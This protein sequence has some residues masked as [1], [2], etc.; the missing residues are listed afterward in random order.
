MR[1][2]SADCCLLSVVCYVVC[3]GQLSRHEL[4][5]SA[6][7]LQS[8][9]HSTPHHTTPHPPHNAPTYFN[10]TPHHT[11]QSTTLHIIP[12]CTSYHTAHHTINHTTPHHTINHTAYHT[13]HSP[14]SVPKAKATQRT[15][16]AAQKTTLNLVPIEDTGLMHMKLRYFRWRDQTTKTLEEVRNGNT[17]TTRAH[18]LPGPPHPLR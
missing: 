15:V 5:L 14:L 1:T 3:E 10:T 4:L 13:N 17:C 8:L 18:H 11:T 6:Y 12:H 7:Y 16:T 2:Q 9:H